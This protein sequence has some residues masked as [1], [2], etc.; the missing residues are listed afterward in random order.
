MRCVVIH[1][2]NL[3]LQERET[4]NP[5]P[6]DVVVAVRGAGI[7]AAD[8]MQRD[9]HYI[10]AWRVHGR[11]KSPSGAAAFSAQDFLIGL[12]E[13]KQGLDAIPANVTPKSR[14]A[15]ARKVR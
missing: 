3:E 4:P 12:A 7:N 8:L 9:G 13:G 15:A 6:H 14:S 10:R 2:G 1:D 11:T 5:G